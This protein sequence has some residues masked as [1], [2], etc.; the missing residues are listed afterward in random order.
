VVEYWSIG[1]MRLTM[2]EPA[3]DHYSITPILHHSRPSD[4]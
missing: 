3:N 1:V 2:A 4:C